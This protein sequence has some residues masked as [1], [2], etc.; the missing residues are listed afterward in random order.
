MISGLQDAEPC[1]SDIA[2]TLATRW[3]GLDKGQLIKWTVYCLL[4]VNWAFYAMEEFYIA[5]HTLRQGGTLLQWTQEFATTIDEFAWFGLLF[6]FELETYA[7]DEALEKRWV[8]WSIH[9]MR[10]VCYLFL[11]HTVY[12]RVN[13]MVDTFAVQSAAAVTELCQVA[14]RDISFGFNYRYQI[15]DEGNCRALSDDS[16]FF[17]LDPSVITDRQGLAMEKKHVWFD[18]QDAVMWLLVVWA[19]ELTVWLQNRNITGGVLMAASHA[20]RLGYAILLF[21]A[22]FWAWAGHWV[23]AWDQFLW[24]AGFWAIERNLSEWREEIREE[25][26]EAA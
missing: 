11:A 8:K 5:S 23:W 6:M 4:L 16:V 18:F 21:H 2:T 26:P 24:I 12:A 3:R 20:A 15:V 22:A 19:I 10:L 13:A 14:D 9:G 7:L 1:V 17:M 25:H